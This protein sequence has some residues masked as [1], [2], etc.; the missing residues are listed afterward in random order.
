MLRLI[1][2]T[3]TAGDDTTALLLALKSSKASL[4]AITINCGNISFDQQV[5][6]ALYT[7]EVA[8]KSGKVPVYPGARRPL[9]REWRTVEDVHGRDGMGDSFFP[10][11]RQ[12]PEAKHAASAIIDLVNGSPGEIIFVEQAPMTNLALALR[13]DPELPRKIRHLFFMG[14]T[15]QYI[16]NI[17]PAAEFNI[18]VDPDAAKAVLH[19]GIQMTM[20]G[21]DICMKHG[22]IEK[23]EMSEIES[24]KTVQSK[25]F[26]DVNRVARRFMKE[27]T[28][29]DVISCPDSIT[30][31]IVLDGSVATDR[32]MK[33]VDVDNE[34]E[35]SRGA[36]W[37]DELDVLKKKPNVEVVYEASKQKFYSLLLKMLRGESY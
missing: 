3:D 15:N 24:L 2:D 23:D 27:K 28:G 18:W 13:L 14:G 6:N 37:V 9:L 22:L 30:M 20:V 16:G 8:G 11:A 5:E 21:W 1:V 34:S 36:T 12:R 17:T 19:S 32:R 29:R 25:F 7:V 26:M 10:K 33:F 31:A 35:L 4:E